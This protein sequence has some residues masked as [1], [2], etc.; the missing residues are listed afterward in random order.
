MQLCP[1]SDICRCEL[2][3]WRI[4]CIFGR[5]FIKRSLYSLVFQEKDVFEK[6]YRIHLGKR[7][8]SGKSSS[9]DLEKLFISKLKED[10]GFQFTSKL[11]VMLNDVTVSSEI[12]EKFRETAMVKSQ[13]FVSPMN[14]FLLFDSCLFSYKLTVV[15]LLHDGRKKTSHSS[16]LSRCSQR[17]LG[18]CRPLRTATFRRKWQRPAISLQHFTANKA[19]A[20]S[21]FGT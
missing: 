8:M 3:F 19:A 14:S 16:S 21:S 17:A 13:R 15:V 12:M 7:L 4:V 6:Y 20:R 2:E 10:C 1:S 18:C 5:T 11:E 9:S